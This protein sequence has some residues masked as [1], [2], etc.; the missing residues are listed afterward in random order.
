MTTGVACKLWG[1]GGYFADR[2]N[3][4]KADSGQFNITG[5]ERDRFQFKAHSLR[6][7]ALIAPWTSPAPHQ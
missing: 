4:T 2:G 5:I 6:N 7:I 3:I 1:M